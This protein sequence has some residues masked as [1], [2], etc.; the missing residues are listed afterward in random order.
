MFP[1]T[2]KIL[3]F[4]LISQ[5]VS[6][7]ALA[8]LLLRARFSSSLAAELDQSKKRQMMQDRVDFAVAPVCQPHEIE[9]AALP[10][11][12]QQNHA[13]APVER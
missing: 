5:V 1:Q 6:S 7:G 3:V 8:A 12:Q 9:H 13:L 11:D 4:C 2:A 10:V